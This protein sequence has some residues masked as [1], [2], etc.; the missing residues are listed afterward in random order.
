VDAARKALHR[1]TRTARQHRDSLRIFGAAAYFATGMLLWIGG[2]LAWDVWQARASAAAPAL[3]KAPVKEVQPVKVVPPEE[4]LA[5]WYLDSAERILDS[6][7]TSPSPSL[8]AFDWQKAEIC[9]SR[10][11]QLGDAEDRT[12]AKLALAR[13]YA[14]LER[15]NAAL[16]SESAA[17][18]Q[19]LKAR[20][21][22][23]LAATKAPSDP[24]PHLGLARVYVYSLPDPEKA[25]AEFAEAERLGAAPGSREIEQQGDVYRIRARRELSRN[26]RQ[27]VRDAAIAKALYRRIE[28]FNETG[29]HLKE[30]EQIHAPVRK[31]RPRRYYWWR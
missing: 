4:N 25:M 31:P 8:S 27:A 16:Y 19:R 12:A 20:D 7:R 2:S 9:L 24:A 17:T 5:K 22:F 10:A 14:T 6:Y 28:G 18:T 29:R 3:K 11:Q 21:E 23:L 13:G 1:V 15:L 26:W 30:L